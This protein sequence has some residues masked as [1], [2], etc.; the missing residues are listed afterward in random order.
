M[1]E[2]IERLQ[3]LDR[4]ELV[5]LGQDESLDR[6]AE[7][8]RHQFKVDVAS[9]SV[10]DRTTQHVKA[11]AGEACE[12]RLRSDSF[13]DQV[14]ISQNA[15]LVDDLS[16]HALFRARKSV[17]GGPRFRSYAGSP[18]RIDGHV[19]GVVCLK[20]H[21]VGVLGE[22]TL[23]Q[24]EAFARIA[25]DLLTAA[26]AR[27]AAERIARFNNDGPIVRIRWQG[28]PAWPLAGENPALARLLGLKDPGDAARFGFLSF[29]H[30]EDRD[31]LIHV[32]NSHLNSQASETEK[33][34]FEYRLVRPD[35]RE[36]WVH[37]YTQ[38]FYGG[39]GRLI[40]VEGLLVDQTDQKQLAL[41]VRAALGRL[42]IVMDAGELG[43][44]ECMLATGEL[45]R[46]Q[47]WAALV[48]KSYDHL[49]P[50]LL[51][52][53]Q[54]IHPLDRARFEK[55]WRDHVEGRSPAFSVECRVRHEMGHWIWMQNFGRA[56]DRDALG[57]P[58]RIIGASRDVTKRQQ[59]FFRQSKQGE[60]FD[61]LNRSQ[62][63]FLIE[64][65][66]RKACEMLLGPIIE[67]SESQ[68]GFIGA[69]A[70]DP[71]TGNRELAIKAISDISW[72]TE[73]ARLYALHEKGELVFKSL[74]NLFGSTITTG[75][76]VV[77]NDVPAHPLAKGVP[78]G[79]PVL[80]RF[81]GLPIK[82]G[83][84]LLGMIGLA[85]RTDEYDG[86]LLDLLAPLPMALGLLLHA[87]R[88]EEQRAET[89]E[90]LQRLASQDSLTGLLNRR[91]FISAIE[92]VAENPDRMVCL[93]IVDLDHFKSV[94]DVHGHGVGDEVLRVFARWLRE[95]LAE[96][97]LCARIGGEEFAVLLPASSEAEAVERLDAI[98]KTIAAREVDVGGIRLGVAFSA[99]LCSWRPDTETV[100]TAFAVADK[101]LYEAKRAGRN[102]IQLGR[103]GKADRRGVVAH[104][105]QIS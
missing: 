27:R 45:H 29:V 63:A 7:L 92:G 64:K 75:S 84:E 12:T 37:Q 4:H 88:L 89:E 59:A 11:S 21:R 103:I 82:Y 74:D 86:E 34:E 100:E 26:Q 43:A 54:A 90:E 46:S 50:S 96:G 24:L 22:D 8:T 53:K 95:C 105:R 98:R 23:A 67:L 94:N 73:S 19:V 102:R 91:A 5:F 101:A 51:S 61:L 6:L 93:A 16:N 70:R 66:V 30:P 14:V 10:L 31:G 15:L 47:Q 55:A 104:L 25:A 71:E 36:V 65:D 49:E 40:V 38:G 48:G 39:D 77:A 60:L 33:Q 97:D 32:L 41:Q 62:Q 76:V 79:H 68:F 17:T 20:D 72:N 81:L 56:T 99:G 58:S 18:I 78:A 52:W 2:E 28:K 13:C 69:V 3:V 44:W 1:P 87:R 83:E 35:G 42:N 80:T 85:N 57:N 9:I